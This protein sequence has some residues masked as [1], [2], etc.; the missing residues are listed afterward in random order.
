MSGLQLGRTAITVHP[1]SIFR[2][3]TK[4]LWNFAATLSET[5]FQPT[6]ELVSQPRTLSS[7]LEHLVQ[8]STATNE[9][10]L[11]VGLL[12]P[13]QK[14]WLATIQPPLQA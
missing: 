13:R 14:L 4:D 1:R 5:K 11:Q 10:L 9:E 8:P 2:F 7:L 6:L 3:T 12:S